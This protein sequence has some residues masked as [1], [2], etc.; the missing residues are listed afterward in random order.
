MA[1]WV[2]GQRT[3]VDIRSDPFEHDLSSQTT[4]IRPDVDQVVCSA[5]KFFIVLDDDD[6]VT[7]RLELFQ[8]VDEPFSIATVQ[9]DAWFV[10]DI[11]GTDQ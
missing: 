4:C 2:L 5:H 9:S 7:Q 10:E 6:S 1:L 8:H 11:E 3:L